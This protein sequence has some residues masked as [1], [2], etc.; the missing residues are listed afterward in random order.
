MSLVHTL[1]YAMVEHLPGWEVSDTKY[2]HR[3]V[4]HE[5]ATGCRVSIGVYSHKGNRLVMS[6][7]YPRH[8]GGSIGCARSWS[9]VAYEEP[10]RDSI[11]MASTRTIESLAHGFRSRLMV[12][13]R[14]LHAKA[15]S[16]YQRDLINDDRKGKA[17]SNIL[18]P[19]GRLAHSGWEGRHTGYFEGP[20][21]I[22]SGKAQMIDVDRARLEIHDLTEAQAVA[23]M[24]VLRRSTKTKA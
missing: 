22:W 3:A 11:T 20:H 7:E 21:N 16:R 1:T 6:V 8:V 12:R 18:G 17:L 10:P 19:S 9:A 14:E 2:D 13:A 5:P 4:I 23:I 15:Y 24:K